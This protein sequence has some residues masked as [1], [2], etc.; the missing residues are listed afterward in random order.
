MARYRPP[1]ALASP[2]I[3]QNGLEALRRELDQLWVRRFD[4]V[5]HLSAAAAE[6]DRSENAEYIYRKKELREIDRRVR[7]LQKRLPELKVVTE[8]P[9]E[10]NRVYFGA[11]V[12]VSDAE[13]STRRYRLVGADEADAKRGWISIDSPMA[14]A[15]RG[16]MLDDEV[17][18]RT[19]AGQHTLVVE[20]IEYNP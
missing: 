11:Y 7:Y 4:V 16:R 6:G 9:P 14:R 12:D 5:K 13:G 18:V 2:Y 1:A 20:S 15:L 17:E 19:P 8:K 3:T 10:C